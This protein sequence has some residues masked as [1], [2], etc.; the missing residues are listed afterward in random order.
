MISGSDAPYLSCI[1]RP[2]DLS[3]E[4]QS[5]ESTTAADRPM[6]FI[7]HWSIGPLW[8]SL[9]RPTHPLHC[10][11]CDQTTTERRERGR[12]RDN[13]LPPIGRCLCKAHRRHTNNNSHWRHNHRY[14]LSGGIPPV[15]ISI[16]LVPWRGC[17]SLSAL[18]GVHNFLG[19]K[20][21]HPGRRQGEAGRITGASCP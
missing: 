16:V 2:A 12:E 19:I 4:S 9:D 17:S 20:S 6:P 21:G 14:R 8:W 13:G 7:M 11:S 10:S 1:F 5:S 15:P 3:A 18:I